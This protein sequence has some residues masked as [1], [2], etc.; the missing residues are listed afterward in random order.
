MGPLLLVHE[1]EGPSRRHTPKPR[2]ARRVSPTADMSGALSKI[3]KKYNKKEI[4]ALKAV[5]DEADADG[6]GEIDCP[7]CE[8][9]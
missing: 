7:S 3:S 2:H 6:S 8:G 5:F 9:L 4:F 1:G